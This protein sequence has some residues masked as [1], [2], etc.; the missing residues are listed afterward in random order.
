ML[1]LRDLAEMSLVRGFAFTHEAVRDWETRFAPL[2]T[3]QLRARRR[4]QGGAK[5]HT[6]ETYLRVA[7]RRCY[8]HR[9]IDREGNLVEAMLGE[10]RGMAAAQR[11]FAQA[12]GI[13]G[14][15]PAQVTTDGYDPYPRAIRETL[16]PD[17]RHRTSRDKNTRIEQDHRSVKQRYS[18]MRG[19]GRVTAAARCCAASE[20]QRRYFRPVAASGEHASLAERRRR[21]HER[22]AAAMTALAAA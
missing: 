11:F 9:A 8:L 7:G 1:S 20:E 21:F 10:R 12:L 19:F 3:A 4:G 22:W 16:G 17:T 15:A 18:P 14:Q 13:A 6:D 2:A 5:W